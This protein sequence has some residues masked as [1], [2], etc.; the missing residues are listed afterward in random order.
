MIFVVSTAGVY[1]YMCRMT[2]CHSPA[3][4][5]V[6]IVHVYIH[7]YIHTYSYQ[8]SQGSWCL[9][10][11]FRHYRHVRSHDQFPYAYRIPGMHVFFYIHTCK[12]IFIH[13]Y[14]YGDDLFGATTS[15][16]CTYCIPGMRVCCFVCVVLHA[17][18]NVYMLSQKY[19]C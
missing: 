8:Y 15:S 11:A 3:H 13:V 16:P 10:H 6:R 5:H 7:T 9:I 19:V 17:C 12:Y 14:A 1:R 2:A 4:T 18:L